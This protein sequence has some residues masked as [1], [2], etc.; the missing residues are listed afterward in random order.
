MNQNAQ[1]VQVQTTPTLETQTN[2]ADANK[3][4]FIIQ[5][6]YVKES[7]F[8]S[9]NAPEVFKKEWKPDVNF[10][11]ENKIKKIE[12]N[13]YEVDITLSFTVKLGEKEAGVEACTGKVTQSGVFTL[14]GFK[15]EQVD[16]LLGSYCPSI[17]FP[18]LR[19]TVADMAMR[20]GYP[21]L[22]IS[23]INFDAIYAQLQEK[24]KQQAQTEAGK[25]TKH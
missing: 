6:I 21:Q 16:H 25:A 3:Q 7:T 15:T 8:A 10:N 20:G 23:P 22:L 12:D 1:D 18:F 4:N 11:L 24:R 19:E 2:L 13:I 17:L 5:K 9:Q 14:T